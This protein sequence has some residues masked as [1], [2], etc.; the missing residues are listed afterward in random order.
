MDWRSVVQASPEVWRA[1]LRSGGE[2]DNIAVAF[3]IGAGAGDGENR[4]PAPGERE[5][6]RAL[7]NV[8]EQVGSFG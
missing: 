6:A 7:L 1:V 4:G 2:V 8:Q 5:A 3:E